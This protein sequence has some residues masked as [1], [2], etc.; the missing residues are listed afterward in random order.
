MIM[1]FKCEELL[2]EDEELGCTITFSDTKISE[3]KYKTV[4]EIMNSEEKYLLIQRTYPDEEYDLDNYYLESSEIDT[5]FDSDSIITVIIDPEKFE[6]NWSEGH[7]QI[8]LNLTEREINTLQEIL[9]SR[10]KDRI[11]IIK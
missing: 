7:L 10:F 1:N 3:D 5:E 9:K 2:I 4:E 11:K 6:I 8:G